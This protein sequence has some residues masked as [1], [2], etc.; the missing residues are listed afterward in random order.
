MD[1]IEPQILNDIEQT[2][3]D[4]GPIIQDVESIE[5]KIESDIKEEIKDVES[6]IED[7]KKPLREFPFFSNKEK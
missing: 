1:N 2:I 5:P 6:V 4:T 7:I 3:S